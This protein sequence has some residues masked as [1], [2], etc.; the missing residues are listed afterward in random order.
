VHNTPEHG[1]RIINDLINEKLVQVKPGVE[2]E[3]GW[4]LGSM[5][6]VRRRA[7][8]AAERDDQILD[9]PTIAVDFGY[10]RKGAYVVPALEAGIYQR[11]LYDMPD[12]KTW[13]CSLDRVPY[14][15]I[16]NDT[17]DAFQEFAG[18]SP[19]TYYGSPDT[20][21]LWS[22][23]REWNEVLRAEHPDTYAMY[24]GAGL[25]DYYFGR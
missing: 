12:I 14:Q 10:G 5:E 2:P 22:N 13:V 16:Q 24:N 3:P 25:D 15:L 23:F 17:H 4:G 9:I 6:E 8:F 11:S 18:I 1:S 19:Q 20:I 7:H 21:P